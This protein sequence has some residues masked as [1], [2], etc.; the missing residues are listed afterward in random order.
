LNKLKTLNSRSISFAV[1]AITSFAAFSTLNT[2]DAQAQNL[3]G[4]RMRN[5]VQDTG[6]LKIPTNGNQISGQG[7]SSIG[8]SGY[9][10]AT[11]YSTNANGTAT[12][13]TNTTN[14]STVDLIKTPGGVAVPA[15]S[16][17]KYGTVANQQSTAG[18]LEGTGKSAST[19]TAE[20]GKVTFSNQ[21]EAKVTGA[22]TAEVTTSS[23]A[24][25][26]SETNKGNARGSFNF[27]GSN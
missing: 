25:L 11:N 18:N 22:R 21:T 9:G 15:A 27:R 17:S 14:I 24:S 19:I 4:S 13:P 7:S 16:V 23:S 6:S 3:P 5:R 20:V 10:A 12:S 8:S 2:S 26:D 1:F